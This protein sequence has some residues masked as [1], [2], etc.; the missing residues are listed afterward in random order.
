[1]A[2]DAIVPHQISALFENARQVFSNVSEIV[3]TADS[4]YSTF[5]DDVEVPPSLV[6]EAQGKAVP[7]P[8]VSYEQPSIDTKTVL[9]VGAIAVAFL[10]F[11]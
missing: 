11:R 3:Q 8:N 2:D 6:S 1:M 5:K 10:L 7:A 4:V 9:L